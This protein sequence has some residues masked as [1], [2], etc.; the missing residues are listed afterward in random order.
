MTRTVTEAGLTFTDPAAYADEDGLHEAFALLRRDDHR[1]GTAERPR[2][3]RGPGPDWFDTT[4]VPAVINTAISN[5]RPTGT[6][7]PVGITQGV[8]PVLIP[9][10]LA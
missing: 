2:T 1:A 9:D 5:L 3:R 10:P 4:S 6:C 7:S 8:K